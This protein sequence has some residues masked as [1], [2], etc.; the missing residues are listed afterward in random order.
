MFRYCLGKAARFLDRMD[1][2]MDSEE[3]EESFPYVWLGF[4]CLLTAGIAIHAVANENEAKRYSGIYR[5]AAITAD[6]N[7]DGRTTTEEWKDVY[8][9]LGIPFNE[10]APK[11]LSTSDLEKYLASE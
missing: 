9:K 8:A 3:A 5:Q 11:E 1:D 7:K 10:S 6:V 4:S 2:A